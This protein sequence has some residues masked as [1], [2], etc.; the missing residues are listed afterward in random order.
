MRRLLDAR[1]LFVACNGFS[2]GGPQLR[3]IESAH[4]LTAYGVPSVCVSGVSFC[5]RGHFYRGINELRG[6]LA[7][8]F[9]KTPPI[10]Y[11]VLESAWKRNCAVLL[12]TMDFVTSLHGRDA[13]F[14]ERYSQYI[15]GLL[16]DNPIAQ[17]HIFNNCPQ[18][19][20]KPV[21]FVEHFHSLHR[22]V[23]WGGLSP[24]QSALLLQEHPS[25][26]EMCGGI[27]R[28]LPVEL[29]FRCVTLLSGE[30]R[31][32]FFTHML[33]MNLSVVEAIAWQPGGTG[34]LFQ[35][36]FGLF[37]L[38]IVWRTT[39][40][41]VQR[42]TNA[43]ATGIPVVAQACPAFEQAFAGH[44][45]LFARNLS[46]LSMWMKRL[47][48]SADLRRRVS[49]SGVAATTQFSATHISSLY[50]RAIRA[51]SRCNHTGLIAQNTSCISLAGSTR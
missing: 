19:R 27:G 51:R 45:V 43:L 28:S 36:V 14:N 24:P 35:K 13:C 8:I 23:S 47:V 44:E 29:R 38:L 42:L 50:A 1:V 34:A 31:L 11:H 20:R 26:D 10:S 32:R 39:T 41:T 25:E 33:S 48:R 3:C 6:L 4:R 9:V 49:D 22:R 37:D 18:L 15:D 40:H 17:H 7:V 16:V 5:N 21:A 12:D 30:H 2:K 46:D